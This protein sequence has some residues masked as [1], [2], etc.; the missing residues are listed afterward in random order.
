MISC[1]DYVIGKKVSL[2]MLIEKLDRPPKMCVIQVGDNPASNTYIKGKKKDCEEVGIECEHV[3][4]EKSVTQD[5]LERTIAYYATIE[6]VDGII[7]QL[8]LPDHFDVER[9]SECIPPEKDVDGFR[10]NSCFEPCT[11]KGIIEWL[12]IN[13]IDF[14]GKVFGVFGRSNIV[15]KPLVNMLIEEG[16]TVINCNSKTPEDFV[17]TT[18]EQADV[19]ISAIGAPKHW[20]NLYLCEIEKPIILIDVGINRDENGKL[21]GDFDYESCNKFLE[22]YSDDSYITPVPG[23]V[24]LLTRV[25]LLDNV[26]RAYRLAQKEA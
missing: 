3:R 24:G 23:S 10:K 1:K 20:T 11:P 5:D 16:A 18:F 25:S 4:L 8:P 9:I 7:V 13:D 14:K 2:Q 26:L 6:P 22:R 12:K 17:L 21:C 19:I 15:G